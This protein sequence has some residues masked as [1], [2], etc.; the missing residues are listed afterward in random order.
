MRRVSM[1]LLSVAGTIIKFSVLL[2]MVSGLDLMSARPIAVDNV[3]QSSFDSSEDLMFFG[4]SAYNGQ[5]F[6]CRNRGC[7]YDFQR[8]RCYGFGRP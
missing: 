4:C 5:P 7:S 6:A 2:L 8:S 3:R 1:S